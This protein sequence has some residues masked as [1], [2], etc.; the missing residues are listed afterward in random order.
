QLKSIGVQ[1]IQSNEKKLQWKQRKVQLDEQIEEQLEQYPFLENIE[2][3]YWH[4]F[5]HTLKQLLHMIQEKQTYEQ[6]MNHIK[7]QL[8]SYNDI[9]TRFVKE[10]EPSYEKY[11]LHLQV[12]MIENLVKRFEQKEQ[13]NERLAGEITENKSQQAEMTHQMNVYE[14]EVEKLFAVGEVDSEDEFYK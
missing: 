12:E 1:W 11:S 2:I 10:I 7:K 4:E 3:N 9:V 5:Y 14:R 13:A 8:M 6:Q